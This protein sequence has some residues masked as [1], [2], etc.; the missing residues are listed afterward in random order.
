MKNMLVDT[1]MRYTTVLLD[2]NRIEKQPW[3]GT[4]MMA[5]IRFEKV[6]AS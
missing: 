5:E 1:Y 2:P 3:E 6:L 4:D